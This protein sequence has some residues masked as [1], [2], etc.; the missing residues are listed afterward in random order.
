MNLENKSKPDFSSQENINSFENRSPDKSV[1]KKSNLKKYWWL[2]PVLGIVVALG[3]ITF[4]RLQEDEP[5]TVT[6][7][8]PLSVRGVKAQREPIQAWISTEGRV[9]AVTYQHLTFEIEG[10]ITYLANINGR[11]LQ[12]GDRVREGQLLARIDDRELIADVRQAEAAVV[13]AQEQ[14]A[15]AEANVA[16]AQAQ[17]AQAQAQLQQAQSAY[18]LA[19]TNLERYRTLVNEG[20]IPEIEFDERQNAFEDAMAQIESARASVNSARQQVVSAQDQVE[21]RAAGVTTAQAR[22]SQA[23][24][25]LEGASIYAPFDGIIAYLNYT[26]GEY[27]TPQA[28]ISQLG[29][30][31]Q[32]ILERIPMVIIDPS[33]YEVVV[34]LA[35]STGEQVRPGQDAFIAS[36]SEIGTISSQASTLTANARATGEVF[37]VNPAIS[38]G[39][40]AITARIKLNPSTTTDVRHGERVLTWIAIAE[41]N[42]AIVVPLNA[43]V[44]RDQVPYVF[45]V[46]PEEGIVEQRQVELGITG[47][48]KQEI[49]SGLEAGEWVVT[50]GQNR[51]TDGASVQMVNNGSEVQP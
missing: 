22:L 15:A 31:Y 23:Q 42:N 19:E 24:V 6:E 45:V 47:I 20:A 1:E 43:V 44:L 25:A 29:G 26:E 38:P 17:V 49:E 9:E 39:G 30:D 18:R 12:E 3:G 11:R 50:Q 16:Q 51:L 37:A 34:D 21:A 13:E 7:T 2:I 4:V 32:G 48:T 46:D 27:F 8:V 41:D 35:G 10:D 5:V 40:R 33:Q 36:E 28:V 14:Q